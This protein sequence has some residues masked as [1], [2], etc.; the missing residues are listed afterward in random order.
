MHKRSSRNNAALSRR[1]TMLQSLCRFSRSYFY[2]ELLRDSNAVLLGI[3]A[4]IKNH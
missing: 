2:D 1:S 4:D 3:P